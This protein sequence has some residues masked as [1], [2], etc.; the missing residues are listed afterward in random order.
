MAERW[1]ILYRSALQS[2]P[3][4]LLEAIRNASVA[5]H[6]RLQAIRFARNTAELREQKSLFVA[7]SD[8]HVLKTAFYRNKPAHLKPSASFD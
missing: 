7:L 3:D 1:T 8:L 6:N 2:A 4:G 5:I